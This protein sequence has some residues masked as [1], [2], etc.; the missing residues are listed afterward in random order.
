[1]SDKPLSD[2]VKQGWEVVDF[3]VATDSAGTQTHC[4]LVRRQGQHKVLN[5][6]KK[7]LGGGLVATEMEV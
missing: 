2:L 5:I 1:M 3:S 7:M 6:R 4:F